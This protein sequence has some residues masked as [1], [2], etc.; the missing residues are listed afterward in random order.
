MP[1][2]FKASKKLEAVQQRI[3]D[4]LC[5]YDDLIENNPRRMTLLEDAARQLYRECFVR[6]RF[7]PV[8]VVLANLADGLSPD[9]ILRSCPSLR[10]EAIQAALAYAADLAQERVL[11]LVLNTVGRG[12]RSPFDDLPYAAA[13]YPTT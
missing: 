3:A 5:P 9:E 8:T 12:L 4:I 2:T 7:P 10:E 6:L 11:Q 13:A 1:D